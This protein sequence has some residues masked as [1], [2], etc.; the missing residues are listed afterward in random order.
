MQG[1]IVRKLFSLSIKIVSTAGPLN[2]A[3]KAAR[4]RNRPLRRYLLP[5][6]RSTDADAGKVVTLSWHA[7]QSLMHLRL[8]VAAHEGSRRR[9]AGY[10]FLLAMLLP[11]PTFRYLLSSRLRHF[12]TLAVRRA[13]FV[14]S[15]SFSFRFVNSTVYLLKEHA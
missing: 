1:L 8:L 12:Y 5:L 9:G 13:S 3:F 4:A 7:C 6:R 14:S 11:P 2:A 10:L 15:Y